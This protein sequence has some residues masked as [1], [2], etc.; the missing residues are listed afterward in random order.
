MKRQTKPLSDN[1]N[2][3]SHNTVKAAKIKIIPVATLKLVTYYLNTL[4]TDPKERCPI[5]VHA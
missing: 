1:L 2:L 5:K 4:E 3:L